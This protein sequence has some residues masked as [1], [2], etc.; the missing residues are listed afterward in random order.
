VLPSVLRV[1]VARPK[2]VSPSYH[3]DLSKLS[4]TELRRASDGWYAV[5]RL[6]GVTHRLWLRELPVKGQPVALELFLDADFEMQSRAAHGLFSALFKRVRVHPYP[7]LGLQR[8]HRLRLAMRALDGRL[9]GK[10]YR[11][12]AEA[13]F[14]NGRVPERSWKTHDL[15]N[16]TIR[17]VQAGLSLMRGGYRGLLRGRRSAS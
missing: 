2:Q 3:L 15:R 11:T 10:S 8:Q 1:S 4:G 13:L 16:R 14:G 5:A 17:L 12:I 7:A 6:K 9:E